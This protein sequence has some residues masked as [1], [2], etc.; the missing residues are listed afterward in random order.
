MFILV[1]TLKF[2]HRFFGV[3]FFKTSNY[4][5][6]WILV[7]SMS[8]ALILGP[9]AAPAQDADSP[10][11]RIKP[12]VIQVAGTWSGTLESGFDGTGTLSLHL[13]QN[14]AKISGSFTLLA[15]NS[16]AS[17]TLKGKISGNEVA[18]TLKN[19]GNQPHCTAKIIA[20]IDDDD[21]M[22]AYVLEGGKQCKGTG[23]FDLSLL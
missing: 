19:T 8:A 21:L 7:A 4:R 11:A 14:K 10:D 6:F 20:T 5:S 12:V 22:G 3:L 2:I 18:L 16:N 1:I 15:T 17:G 9:R 23:T 13:T